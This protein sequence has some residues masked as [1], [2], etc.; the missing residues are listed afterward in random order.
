MWLG[1]SSPL[2]HP[3]P[4][5]GLWRG[6]RP[7]TSID[8]YDQA[9]LAEKTGISRKTI[10]LIETSESVPVDARRR[11]ILEELRTKMEDELNVEFVFA[12]TKTGEGVRLRR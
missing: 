4:G 3:R 5:R 7:K 6:L 2:S 9:T 11:R 1:T 12:G 10:G 8:R